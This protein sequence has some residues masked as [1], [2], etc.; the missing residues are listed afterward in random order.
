MKMGPPPLRRT[1]EK[2][3][4]QSLASALIA[5]TGHVLL[6]QVKDFSS[7]QQTSGQAYFE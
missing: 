3:L 1:S 4:L 5:G 7:A 6:G 2:P